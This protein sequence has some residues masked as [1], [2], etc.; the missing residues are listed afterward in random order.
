MRFFVLALG[1]VSVSGF[2]QT[3]FTQ[4]RDERWRSDLQQLA[5]TLPKVHP[6]FFTQNSRETFDQA[7]TKLNDSI[8]SLSDPQI[9]AGMM[10]L[11]SLGGDANTAISPFQ[12]AA[13]FHQFPLQFL[14]FPEGIYVTS[15]SPSYSR[16]IGKRLIA[17]NNTPVDNVLSAVATLIPHENEQWVKAQAPSYL[18]LP[19][20]L[21]ALGITTSGEQARFTFEDTEGT[22]SLRITYRTSPLAEA[23]PPQPHTPLYRR[24]QDLLYWFD[25][26]PTSRTL[27]IKYN[28]GQ[29]SL[30]LPMADFAELLAE[31]VR[32]NPVERVVMDLRNNTGGN[33]AVMQPLVTALARALTS[34]ALPATLRP[35][36]VIGKQTFSAGMLNAIQFKQLGATLIGEPTGGKPGG[37]GEMHTFKLSNSGL[38]VSHSTRM[39]LMPQFRGASVE[40]DLPVEVHAADYFANKDPVLEAATACS[41]ASPCTDA[42]EH[43]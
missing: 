5:T 3:G 18:V 40:P 4:T 8:P 35:F 34:G 22:F 15:A 19:E 38:V 29:E 43:E 7:V 12:A 10:R 33:T 16:A 1:L 17:I 39:I 20:L 6:N 36:V 26:L 41:F 21:H 14:S 25:Y 13:G 27:Y 23:L 2:A 28:K 9:I 24:Y 32:E 31:F 11:V 30:S 37:F 42:P